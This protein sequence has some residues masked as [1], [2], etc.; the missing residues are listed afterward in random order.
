[1]EKVWSL[2]RTGDVGENDGILGRFEKGAEDAKKRKRTRECFDNGK[3]DKRKINGKVGKQDLSFQE[4][5]KARVKQ[6]IE[7]KNGKVKVT[8][9]K[10]DQKDKL[11]NKCFLPVLVLEKIFSYLDWKELGRAM[12]VCQRWEEVGGHPSLWTQF[13]LQ[14]T[15]QRLKNFPK[16]RRLDW[17]KTLTINLSAV[18]SKENFGTIIQVALGALPR[19]EELFILG[20]NCL[21]GTYAWKTIVKILKAGKNKLVRLGARISGPRM[22]NS[23]CLYYISRCDPGTITFL[24]RTLEEEGTLSIYGLPGLHLT[25]EILETVCTSKGKYALFAFSTNLMINQGMDI[26][27]LTCLLKD[28]VY[29]FNWFGNMMSEDSKKQEMAPL[30]TILDLLDRKSNGVFDTF[31]IPKIL[32]LRSNWVKRLGGRAKLEAL[33]GDV[34]KIVHSETGLRLGKDEEEGSEDV[35]EEDG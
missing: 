29:Y 21:L 17:V 13:P 8:R 31:D 1:M 32:L 6:Q 28:H 19:L 14:V 30:N 24:K 23:E 4:K 2:E 18:R 15:R 26:R 5:Q 10:K 11:G 9:K 12:L 7:E 25:D 34:V 22:L 3:I 16:F 27:K 35:E 20:N 33:N